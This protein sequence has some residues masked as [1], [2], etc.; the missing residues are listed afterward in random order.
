MADMSAAPEAETPAVLERRFGDLE[1]TDQVGDTAPGGRDEFA[2]LPRQYRRTSSASGGRP[3]FRAGLFSPRFAAGL[4]RDMPDQNDARKIRRSAGN[5]VSRTAG[6][7]RGELE[8]VASA[9]IA[10]ARAILPG[11]KRVLF[12]LAPFSWRAVR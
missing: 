9:E 2:A 4:R 12:I 10:R 7:R 5:L 6:S 11:R 3:S 1:P 8:P